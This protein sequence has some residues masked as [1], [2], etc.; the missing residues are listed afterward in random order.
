MAEGAV[1][2]MNI[3]QRQASDPEHSRWVSASAGSGK[4]QVLAARVLRLLLGGVEPRGILCL[5]F[6]KAAAAEM[7]DRVLGVLARWA[8]AD[9]AA[10]A[11]DLAALGVTADEDRLTLA[12]S[13][14]ARVLET[15]GGLAIQTVH[16]LAQSLLARFPLEAGLTPGFATQDDRTGFTRT[17]DALQQ[18]FAEALSG[19]DQQLA[20]DIRLLAEHQPETGV[21][22][23]FA[24]LARYRDA[25]E[26]LTSGGADAVLPRL[27]R[28]VALPTAPTSAQLL[29]ATLT[30]D[31]L[32]R[33]TLEDIARTWRSIN[34]EEKFLK[35]GGTLSAWLALAPGARGEGLEDVFKLFFTDA[36]PGWKLKAASTL[37]TKKVFG[38]RDAAL[39]A[40]IEAAAPA[41]L[42]AYERQQLLAVIDRTAALLR[43]AGRVQSLVALD[44]AR[45]GEVDFDDLISQA[46]ALLGT[47]GVGDWVRYKLGYAITHVLVDEGQD[48]NAVQW[49]IID[50]LTQ[51]FF[52]GEGASQAPQTVFAVGDIKQ[53][54]FGFQGADP[55]AFIAAERRYRRQLEAAGAALQQVPLDMSFR[56][57]EAVLHVVDRAL[58]ALGPDALGLPE[59]ALPHQAHRAGIAGSVTLWDA[60]PPADKQDEDD[61]SP[62]SELAW[63]PSGQRRMARQLA[64]QISQWVD[65]GKALSSRGRPVQWG[66]IMV[67]LRTRGELATA[68]VAELKAAGVPVA[69][70]DRMKL[71]EPFAVQY[72]MTLIKVVLAPGDDLSLATVLVSPFIGWNDA[73]LFDLAH[74]REGRSLFAR[75]TEQ[76]AHD[77]D[78]ASALDFINRCLQLA[79]DGAPFRL[80][81][82]V[83]GSL[84]GMKRLIARLGDEA[85]DPVDVLVSEALAY[86]AQGAPSLQGFLAWIESSTIDVKRDPDGTAR[87]E[88]RVMTVHGAKGLQA[89]IVILADALTTL[90]ERR[91]LL[92]MALDDFGDV[93]FWLA[94]KAAAVGPLGAALVA[95][96]QKTSREFWRLFYVAMTRAEDQLFI[97]GWLPKKGSVEGSWHSHVKTVLVDMGVDWLPDPLW[98]GALTYSSGTGQAVTVAV[99]QPAVAVALP[100]WALQPA[101]PEPAP[102]RP[103]APSRLASEPPADSPR[104]AGQL[105]ARL[106]GTLAHRLLERLPDLAPGARAGAAAR[107]LGREAPDWSPAERQGLVDELM[108]VLNDSAFAAVFGADALAEAP[109]SAVIGT[110]V[111]AGQID[112]LLI[113][114]GRILI[115]DYKTG[116]SL[117]QGPE[118]VAPAYLKQMAVYCQVLRRLYP[119]RP[120][121][122]ALLWTRVPRLMALPEGLLKGY[123]L[124]D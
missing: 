90:N 114:P 62:T 38:E 89:P 44:K 97:G 19:S 23:L 119:D 61:W 73:Q 112:R 113:E 4:T 48:T 43:L 64:R 33:A 29:E 120:V 58:S 51:E 93:P 27:R 109:I 85:R 35:L 98:G 53:S 45:A 86:E 34:T 46:A 5:T 105:A 108:A 7:A 26:L 95:D 103:L 111:V 101:P 70:V 110:Q 42:L 28:A 16:G 59:P 83:L 9:R 3:T 21:R 123:E 68:L 40:L 18:L 82:T 77:P 56:S 67:L 96:R 39:M 52:A 118:A 14:F 102:P 74:G 78:A 69:G 122:A 106:R 8:T 79:E 75:L 10:V 2:P 107:W 25:I 1:K 22:E 91:P 84:G 121:Q 87:N 24:D 30:D 55:D 12:H 17:S 32:G 37:A 76:A 94:R 50:A 65:E 99:R 36:K 124:Q 11:A 57:T 104:L 66:D 63:Q 81:D 117:P 15:D 80:L 88:V 116:S 115:V 72:L 13:L 6:T 71:S 60:I 92:P 100:A 47:A 20:A 31:A 49:S 54:I 41:L